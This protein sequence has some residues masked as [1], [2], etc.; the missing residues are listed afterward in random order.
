V[1][2]KGHIERLAILMLSAMMLFAAGMLPLKSTEQKSIREK[3]ESI[4]SQLP[5]FRPGDYRPA[6]GFLR[7]PEAGV[8]D[9]LMLELYSLK[10]SKVP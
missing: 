7:Q 6:S 1:K 4:A 3:L 10:A 5:C 2:G 9:R 8:Y